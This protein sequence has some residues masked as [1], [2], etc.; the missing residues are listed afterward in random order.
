[1]IHKSVAT[2]LAGIALLG[3][4][5]ANSAQSLSLANSPGVSG[6]AATTAGPSNEAAGNALGFVLLAVVG[7][8]AIWAAVELVSG[9]DDPDSP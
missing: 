4:T 1:M 3:A 6:R 2:L 8:L 9:D 7:G 5:A